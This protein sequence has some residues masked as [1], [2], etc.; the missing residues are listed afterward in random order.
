MS[1]HYADDERSSE[2]K[3]LGD[4][5]NL[6]SGES[7]GQESKGEYSES[8]EEEIRGDSSENPDDLNALS[9]LSSVNQT[10]ESMEENDLGVSSYGEPVDHSSPKPESP[11]AEKKQ[12]EKTSSTAS[13]EDLVIVLEEHKFLKVLEDVVRELVEK[14]ITEKIADQS[15]IHSEVL[16][17][18]RSSKKSMASDQGL[19][20]GDLSQQRPRSPVLTTASDRL[21]FHIKQES[22]TVSKPKPKPKPKRAKKLPCRKA[23]VE[24]SEQ[25]KARIAHS[26][27]SATF[28]LF[29]NRLRRQE[30]LANKLGMCV[31]VSGVGAYDQVIRG[32]LCETRS[33]QRSKEGTSTSAR[34]TLSSNRRAPRTGS[35]YPYADRSCRASP[36][37]SGAHQFQFVPSGCRS[38]GVLPILT[39]KHVSSFYDTLDHRSDVSSGRNGRHRTSVKISVEAHGTHPTVLPKL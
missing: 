19:D 33:S 22:R 14:L 12:K 32:R 10:S 20:T 17:V 27:F 28:T 2:E 36:N 7:E 23:P 29:M 6:Q 21:S 4:S 34:T 31:S 25:A 26:L 38:D 3:V 15:S 30:A 35:S 9:L 11:K 13:S 18:S 5:N 24:R 16:R 39:R 8:L 37:N 1:D